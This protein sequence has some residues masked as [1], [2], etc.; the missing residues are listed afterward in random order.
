MPL[1]DGPANPHE[2]LDIFF[3]LNSAK[4]VYASAMEALQ[5]VQTFW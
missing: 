3:N 1:T 4:G 2:I 5:R